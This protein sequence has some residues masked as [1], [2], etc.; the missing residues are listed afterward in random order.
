MARNG[1]NWI[2]DGPSRDTRSDFLEK[3]PGCASGMY[4]VI[5]T[6]DAWARWAAP[7]ASLIYTSASAASALE[8]SFV[9]FL[10]GEAEVFQQHDV[11]GLHL[12]DET[13]TA[14]LIQSGA[15]ITF[16][17]TAGAVWPLGARLYLG[18]NFLSDVEVRTLWIT[19]APSSTARLMV[20]SAG[21][22]LVSSVICGEIIE[23]DIVVR[24]DNHTLSA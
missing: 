7:K 14:A 18:S 10:R 20:G 19:F 22:N 15:N 3:V 16:A 21:S 23:R 8:K 2:F 13:S 4:F 5:P 12:G 11:A 9:I 6:V 1:R 17:G 24:S